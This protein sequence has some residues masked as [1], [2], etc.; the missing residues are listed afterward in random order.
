MCRVEGKTGVIVPYICH[1]LSFHS[2]ELPKLSDNLILNLKIAQVS[3][4]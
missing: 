3:Q 4:K 2:C 1:D